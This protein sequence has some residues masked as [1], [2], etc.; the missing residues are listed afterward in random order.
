MN[1]QTVVTYVTPHSERDIKMATDF[2][3]DEEI[4]SFNDSVTTN[5]ES[6]NNENKGCY[7]NEPEK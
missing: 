1:T 2:E 6:D 7:F 5:D 3:S 4:L